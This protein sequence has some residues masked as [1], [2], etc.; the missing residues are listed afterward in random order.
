MEG[1]PA[2]SIYRLTNRTSLLGEIATLWR[3]SANRHRKPIDHR[4]GSGK[5][6][7]SAA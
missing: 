4:N 7:L 2:N 3:R 6:Q 1:L 5:D